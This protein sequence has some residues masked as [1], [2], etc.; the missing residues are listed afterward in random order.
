MRL[1]VSGVSELRCT[2]PG[3]LAVK[4]CSMLV[5][6]VVP[7][8]V[9]WLIRVVIDELAARPES[10]AAVALAALCAVGAIGTVGQYVGR[11]ADREISRRAG[12][13]GM[14][15]LFGAIVAPVGI[16]QLED[17][18]VQDRIRLAQQAASTGMT[19]LVQGVFGTV[20]PAITSAGFL[21][22]L[23]SISPLSTGLVLSS[24]VPAMAVQLRVSRRQVDVQSRT[25]PL[26]RRQLFYTTLMLDPRAASEMRLFGLGEL[27]R[28][29]L[30]AEVRAVQVQERATDQ[31]M[32]RVDSSLGVLTAAVS[33]TALFLTF[34][35]IRSGYA[36]IGDLALLM[37]ALAGV[38]GSL[39]GLVGQLGD[40]G[41][42]LALYAAYHD[43]VSA[44]T[45]AGGRPA[46]ADPGPLRTGIE[47]RD[48]WFRYGADQAWVLRGVSLA[49]PAGESLALV[50]LNGAGKSTL[51]KLLCRMYEPVQG[52]ITWDGTDLR[53]LDPD[54]LRRRVGALFQDYMTYQMTARENIGVGD[55]CVLDSVGE[56]SDARI[57]AAASAA[58]IHGTIEA[59]PAGYQTM[60]GRLFA[61]PEAAL[62]AGP[63]ARKNTRAGAAH[64]SGVP[65]SG[66]ASLS[67]GQWQ[68]I[69]LARAL[70]RDGADLLILDEPSSGI[71]A[72]AEL[73]IHARLNELR[74][75]R[76]SL[77]ISHRLAALRMADSIAVLDDGIVIEHGSHDTLMQAD[78]M[79]ARLFRTQAA[80]YQLAP[81]EQNASG[82]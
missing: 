52:Q 66:G 18:A 82:R 7:V 16:G 53:Q 23:W 22:A 29:R 49:I 50:G 61:A 43:I 31:M 13:H 14:S 25:S 44:A 37:A 63:A 38:Q 26:L 19:R 39:A 56:R 6:G 3:P 67:G 21:A 28:D 46:G 5:L 62:P 81:A 42:A 74:A 64:A 80:G 11:Y 9:A 45:P 33:A 55:A 20:Q 4:V 8:L 75:G 57:Q 40:V 58:G 17:P 48:V 12:R 2:A 36:T 59:L 65:L 30:V 54:A 71:D 32:L 72:A 73:E 27:F 47:L 10:R 77:L 79:Y 35:R 41:P 51:V 76:T 70:L 78:G 68:R 24:A 1:L 69:A 34:V 60:L 15:R